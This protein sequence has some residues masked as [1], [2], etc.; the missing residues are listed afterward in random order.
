[1]KRYTIVFATLA[2]LYSTSVFAQPEP[3]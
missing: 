2:V 3:V 1:M